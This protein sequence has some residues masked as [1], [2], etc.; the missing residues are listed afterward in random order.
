MDVTVLYHNY[1]HRVLKARKHSSARASS[2]RAITE[3][4][5]FNKHSPQWCP[6]FHSEQHRVSMLQVAHDINQRL[7]RL[8]DDFVS[9]LD[10]SDFDLLQEGVLADDHFHLS[11][12]GHQLLAAHIQSQI[13]YCS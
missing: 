11:L 5:Y 4:S 9:F 12:R 3:D 7:A 2:A 1:H 13:E 10:V 6:C 8:Q